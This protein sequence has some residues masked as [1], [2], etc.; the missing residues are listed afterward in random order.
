MLGIGAAEK[1]P[2]DSGKSCVQGLCVNDPVA[3]TG[4]C[5]YGDDYVSNF[6]LPS[7]VLTLPSTLMTCGAAIDYLISINFDFVYFCQN[8][9]FNFGSA[10]CETCNSKIF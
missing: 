7:N 6:D 5:I 8:K 1:T 4:N 3:P 9:N 10:C 2:C